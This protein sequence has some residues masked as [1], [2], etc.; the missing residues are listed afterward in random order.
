MIGSVEDEPFCEMDSWGV[1][2]DH[3]GFRL[4]RRGRGRSDMRDWDTPEYNAARRRS[5]ERIRDKHP[6]LVTR[7]FS[8][9]AGWFQIL[10]D[11]FD[12]VAEIVADAAGADFTLTQVKEKFGGLRVYYGCSKDI[13]DAVSEAVRRAEESAEKTCDVCGGPGTPRRG[14]W[15]STRCDEHADGAVPVERKGVDR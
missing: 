10:E 14:G 4:F 2:Q 13:R 8:C 12:D 3:S 6:S 9:E 5:Y 7:G 1:M 15:F 11:F